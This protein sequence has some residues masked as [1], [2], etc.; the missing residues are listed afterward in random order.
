MI[1]TVLGLIKIT[2]H[3]Q[4]DL[5]LGR[6]YFF[7]A[8]LTPDAEDISGSTSNDFIEEDPSQTNRSCH[9]ENFI[10]NFN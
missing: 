1:R 3:H 5:Y 7:A 9:G 10:A 6:P 4:F 2:W 8:I